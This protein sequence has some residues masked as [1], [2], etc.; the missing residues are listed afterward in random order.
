[1]DSIGD[2]PTML[3]TE[4][5]FGT[6]HR[7]AA[8]ESRLSQIL[9]E[10][11]HPKYYLSEKAC[12]GILNRAN[13]RG[14][15][16]PEILQKALENQATRSSRGGREIDSLGKRAGKGALI[17]EELSATLGVTQDQTLITPL[18][19]ITLEGNGTRASHR[20]DGYVESEV[21]YTLN[22]TEHHGVA[23]GI[24]IGGAVRHNSQPS[25]ETSVTL[26][27]Q[28]KSGD[29]QASVIVHGNG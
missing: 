26:T 10:T 3:M 15:K 13:K 22:S 16:L 18:P 11:A 1:M 25:E 21:S 2:A 5:R 7:N 27:S 19:V 8:V 9:T 24:N 20:G 6:A 28:A 14:K 23:Y 17:Q 12:Q 4:Y 29:T